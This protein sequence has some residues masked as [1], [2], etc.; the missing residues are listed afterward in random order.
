ML[1]NDINSRLGEID[2]ELEAL[3]TLP[4]PSEDDAARSET[5]EAEA[6]EL[7]NKRIAALER[8]QRIAEARERA[9]A[10]GREIPGSIQVMRKVSP[11]DVDVRVMTPDELRDG[12]RSILDRPEA[13]HIDDEGKEKAEKLFLGLD[14]RLARWAITTSR[15]EYRSAFGKYASGR[16]HLMTN[17]EI[18]AT[19]QVDYEARAYM[20]L[21]DANGGFA[22][23]VLLDPAVIYTGNGNVNPMRRIARQVTGMD[24]TW[25]GVSS[26]G[27][28]A[29]WDGEATE[30]SDDTPTFAQPSVTAYKAQAFAGMS[31]EIEGDWGAIATEVATLF[32]EAKDSLETTATATG[33]G[34]SQ[35]WGIISALVAGSGTVA[36]PAPTT[37]GQLGVADVR[38]LFATLPPRYRANA[39]WTMSLDTLNEV[40]GFDTTGGKSLQTVDLQADYGFNL[41]GRPVY[42][43]SG[44]PD[45]S[46]TTGVANI[47]VVG[48]FRNYVLFDRVGARLEVVPHL[49]TS[50]NMRP[51]GQRGLLFWWRFGADSVNDNAFR[52]LRN[53]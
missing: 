3:A 50:T 51:N 27:V 14:Q 36:N 5:L 38:S 49:F 6:G 26:A 16:Q 35:P 37:D 42:E 24:D 10:E 52:L 47:M 43:H 31:V 13:R 41:L 9:K 46:G 2:A 29:S 34:S 19:S 23:P 53:V 18:I 17:D 48:D 1:I 25:R 20:A 7:R 40:R 11:Y 28:T 4:D 45:F 30:V 15:P 39:S 12:A 21:A 33:S 44:F 22:V 8:A 32:A